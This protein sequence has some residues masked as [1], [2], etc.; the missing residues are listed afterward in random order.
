MFAFAALLL[1]LV[2]GAEAMRPEHIRELRY[3]QL[4][5]AWNCGLSHLLPDLSLSIE[6]D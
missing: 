5:L 4:Q 1:W 3:G 6:L 2:T